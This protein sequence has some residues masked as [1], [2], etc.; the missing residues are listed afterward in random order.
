[1]DKHRKMPLKETCETNPTYPS[2][3][4]AVYQ[5]EETGH[6]SLFRTQKGWRDDGEI[7]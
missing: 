5:A 2:E 3:N 4:T 1:M 6:L 7:F